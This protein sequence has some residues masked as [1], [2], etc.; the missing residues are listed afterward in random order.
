MDIELLNDDCLV[1]LKKLP[2]NSVDS[3]VTDPPAG[4]GLMS[5]HTGMTWDNPD[6]GFTGNTWN[7]FDAPGI[8]TD[9]DFKAGATGQAHSHGVA[10]VIASKGV[11]AARKP[12]IEFIRQV[13]TEVHRVLKP[14]AYGLVWALPRTSHWTATG[15]EDAGFEVVTVFTHLYSCL[16]EDTELLVEGRW[17]PYNKAAV[18]QLALCYDPEHDTYSWQNIEEVVVYDH[19]DTAYRLLGDHTDQIVSR[20]HRCLIEQGGA[21][22]LRP[23]EEIAQEQEVR[24]PVLENLP[25][26]LEALPVPNIRASETQK[27]LWLLSGRSNT[28]PKKGQAANCSGYLSK[29][30]S[31]VSSKKSQVYK[32]LEV[33]LK[34]VLGSTT[35]Q[36]ATSVR[37]HE[38]HRRD[39]KIRMD[40]AES[41]GI[42]TEDVR[43]KQPGLEGWSYHFQVAR[44]LCG[45]ALRALSSRVSAN[46]SKGW[47]RN[48]ASSVCGAGTAE[49]SFALGGGAPLEPYSDRQPHREPGVIFEQSRPQE[50]RGSRFTSA[51]LVRVERTDYE[52]KVWCVRVPTGAF[53]A[54]RKGKVFVTGNSGFPKHKNAIKPAAEHWI[55]VRKEPEGT[56]AENVVKYGT[57]ALN[58]DACRVTTTDSL[59]GGAYAQA[60]TLRDDGWKMQRGGAGEFKQPSGR[61]PSNFL[62]SH[63]SACKKLGTKKV[64]G[65]KTIERPPDPQMTSGWG[66]KRQGG[67]ISYPTDADGLE[68]VED[69]E[70]ALG[71]QVAELEKQSLGASKFFP[72]FETDDG[73][74]PPLFKYQAKVAQDE[75]YA[76]TNSLY[77]KRTTAGFEPISFVE[78]AQLGDEEKRVLKETGNFRALRDQGN[79]H[80]TVKSFSLMEWCIKCVTPEGGKV[81]DPFLGSG[82]TA[83]AC[84]LNGFGCIGIEREKT[85]FAIAQARLDYT[86]LRVQVAKKVQQPNDDHVVVPPPT[87]EQKVEEKPAVTGM[88]LSQDRIAKLVRKASRKGT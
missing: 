21:Y 34:Q 85:Y 20:N 27:E 39:G 65:Q 31:R 16:S 75:K 68:T 64:Q 53:V 22:V 41:E 30:W 40:G 61:W 66:H 19:C 42:P 69:W 12:F 63:S 32:R 59:N 26:L 84:A 51:D 15:L 54:R 86:K 58:I 82:T 50:I 74:S 6:G 62:V 72:Q 49:M 37:E 4:I 80:V 24:V 55:M 81:L 7:H 29:L 3:L 60:G 38:N 57:G 46:G 76:G 79:V 17:V 10:G 45:S 18:G 48:G 28:A 88:K 36:G 14:G 11:V 25:S 9:G 44:Q 13:F 78:W 77:W 33:L 71:C 23:A 5:S 43:A 2:D 87:P 52:G 8:V 1:A 35:L 56:V 83:C 67:Q 47:L 73:W 70:C